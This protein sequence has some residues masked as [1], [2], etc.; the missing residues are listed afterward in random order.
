MPQVVALAFTSSN[1]VI[2]VR[3]SHRVRSRGAIRVRLPPARC[4]EGGQQVQ[5][6][7]PTARNSHPFTKYAERALSDGCEIKTSPQERPENEF[8]C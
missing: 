4:F 1:K 3:K 7:K 6:K 5:A 2:T 8:L